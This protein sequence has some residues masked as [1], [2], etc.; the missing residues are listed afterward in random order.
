MK[1]FEEQYNDPLRSMEIAL[2]KTYRVHDTMTDWETL[3]ALNGLLRAYTAEQRRRQLPDLKLK[4]LAQQCY[5]ELKLT[6]EG[7]L[8]RAPIV[9]EAGQIADLSDKCLT[10]TEIINCLKRV[11]KSVEMWQKEGGQRGYFNFVDPFL[12]PNSG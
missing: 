8:G 9:D 1:T 3:N 4:P 7:W 6:C 10:L 2:V 12:P 11:R 5:D